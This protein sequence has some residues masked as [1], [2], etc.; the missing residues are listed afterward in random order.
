MV[1]ADGLLSFCLAS[2]RRQRGWRGYGHVLRKAGLDSTGRLR[3]MLVAG[4][5][6][7][8]TG[9]LHR[10]THRVTIGAPPPSPR[11]STPHGE[12]TPSTS[13]IEQGEEGIAS[14]YGPSFNGKQTSSGEVYDMYALTAA[15]RTL[16]FGTQVRVHDLDDDE[17]VDVTINDRG[18]FVEGRII[19]L[20]LAAA[21]AI[22]MVGPGTARVQLE[23]LNPDVIV[24]PGAI[25]G[26]FAVQVGAFRD[27]AN[28]ER[29][30]S[31]IENSFGPVEI[32]QYDRGDSIFYRVRVG[33][34][35]DEQDADAMASQLQ[36]AGFASET[37]I[38][39]LN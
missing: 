29:L 22:H 3:P 36:A 32:Q 5:M 16:P 34:L 23:I 24:G 39:R 8:T 6:A 14:W 35:S 11:A 2:L 31:R 4:L 17:S 26:I 10:H 27:P 21:R 15:H 28:A 37:F 18:P 25:P 33:R 20:S 9:C 38:V 30:K 7:V 1:T 13:V 19:D 12:Q